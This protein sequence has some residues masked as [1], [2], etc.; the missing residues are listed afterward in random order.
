[1]PN[2]HFEALYCKDNKHDCFTQ[3]CRHFTLHAAIKT[4]ATVIFQDFPFNPVSRLLQY[5]EQPERWTMLCWRDSK[6]I[7]WIF[8]PWRCRFVH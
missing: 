7:S 3:P 6:L 4:L 8:H 1:M 2:G 5:M